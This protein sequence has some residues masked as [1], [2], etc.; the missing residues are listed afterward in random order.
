MTCSTSSRRAVFDRL[1]EAG[2]TEEVEKE[3][4][5]PAGAK[6][7]S[8]SQCSQFLSGLGQIAYLVAGLLVGRVVVA[9][10]VDYLQWV[11]AEDLP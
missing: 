4:V 10:E 9:C 11:G 7:I 6:R 2:L 1:E 8:V 5:T 3:E